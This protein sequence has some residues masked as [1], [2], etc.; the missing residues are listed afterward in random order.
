[1]IGYEL[2]MSDYELAIT[3]MACTL[4]G[5]P[6]KTDELDHILVKTRLKWTTFWLEID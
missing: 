4:R 3:T 1:M 6:V 2:A 5:G